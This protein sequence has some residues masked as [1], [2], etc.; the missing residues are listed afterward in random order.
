MQ[1]IRDKV[2][3]ELYT[4]KLEYFYVV[5]NYFDLRF[6]HSNSENLQYTF[7][8]KARVTGN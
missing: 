7:W 1:V 5:E 3:L 6:L 2:Y 8:F 4:I